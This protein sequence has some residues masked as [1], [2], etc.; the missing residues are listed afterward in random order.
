ML[1]LMALLTFVLM[2]KTAGSYYDL[3]KMDPSVSPETIER[4]V[5]LYQLDRPVVVQYLHWVKNLFRF[6]FGYS[7]Y[8]NIPVARVIS[9][10]LWNTFI[11]SFFSVLITWF[12]AVPL[13]DGVG[14]QPQPL[15]RPGGSAFFLYGAFNAGIFFGDAAAVSGPVGPG[16]CRWEGCAALIMRVFH[17]RGGSG[18]WRGTW[19]FP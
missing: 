10:R 2:Q 5:Q 3:L 12:I 8:F 4:Y 13:G 11:L 1:L 9:G 19:R 17:G 6:E 16:G 18:I 15:G 7:F 14:G